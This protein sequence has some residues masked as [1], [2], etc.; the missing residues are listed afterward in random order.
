LSES[1][2]NALDG[3]CRN[4]ELGDSADRIVRV[5]VRKKLI[6]EDEG[7]AP[8]AEVAADNTALHTGICL[9]VRHLVRSMRQREEGC[10]LFRYL[11]S[12]I[13]ASA[14]AGLLE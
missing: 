14:R 9:P 4:V 1:V 10:D 6:S 8:L 2:Y 5:S 7:R 12:P 3:M 13:F 11:F